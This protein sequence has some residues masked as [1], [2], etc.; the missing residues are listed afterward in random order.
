MKVSPW[1]PKLIRPRF[2]RLKIT[3]SERNVRRDLLGISSGKNHN[4]HIPNV[5][6]YFFALR[7]RVK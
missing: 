4:I 3:N 6:I 1:F 5:V 2:S 7:P